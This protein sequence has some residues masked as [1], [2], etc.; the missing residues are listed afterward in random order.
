MLLRRLSGFKG[1]PR[2]DGERRFVEVLC[3]I[4]LSVEHAEATIKAFDGDF[5][6]IREMRDTA[7]GLRPQFQV[8]V[9]ERKQWEAECGKPDPKWSKRFTANYA[10][11]RVAMLWESIRDAMYYTE[12]PGSVS[13][14]SS[15]WGDVKREHQRNHG[16]EVA[17][18]RAELRESSW[19]A[20]METDWAKTGPIK[21]APPRARSVPVRDTP[22]TEDDIKRELIKA[23]REPGDGE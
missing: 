16:A 6:T 18:F 21:K 11:E 14:P 17:A 3:E 22:I 4:S 9:D 12:G 20:L 5:P 19:P 1:Y 7:F 8:K 13:G 15:F 23:G 10:D 2:G